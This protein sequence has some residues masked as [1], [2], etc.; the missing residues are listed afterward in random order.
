VEKSSTLAIEKRRSPVM[1]EKLKSLA[2]TNGLL[3]YAEFVQ[4]ALYDPDLGYYT[5]LQKRVGKTPNTDFYTST[6]MGPLFGRLVAES[7]KTLLQEQEPGEFTFIEIGA[8]PESSVLDGVIHP[9][10][11]V[12]TLRLG[13][14]IRVNGKVII[15]A[16]E[17]LD[18][19]PFNRLVFEDGKWR[20]IG[21]GMADEKLSEVRME[22]IS[23]EI[24]PYL[25][26]LPDKQAN[27]YH[28]DIPSGASQ[29]LQ[30]LVEQDW[31][32][33]LLTLD[34]GKSKAELLESTPQGTAR[35]YRNHQQLN[36]LLSN[37]GEQDLTCH[38]CWDWLEAILTGNRFEGVGTL[39]QESLFMRYAKGPI[40]EVLEDQEDTK[41]KGRLME[42]L[43]PAHLGLKFQALSGFRK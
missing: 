27:G 13:A 19:Q 20:E 28:V 36:E 3:T 6:S 29:I 34:Y 2:G 7:A 11:E 40:K 18:A 21:V 30:E 33:L 1:L 16:N 15:F 24:L 9:F 17:W 23:R 14:P 43:H 35:A 32:G 38:V 5:R 37:P 26:E 8:E 22:S 4:T 25:D 12:Q 42:L 41:E 31:N 39:R 10:K